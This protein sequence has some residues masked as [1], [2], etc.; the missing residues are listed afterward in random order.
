MGVLEIQ[1]TLYLPLRCRRIGLR[2]CSIAK[3]SNSSFGIGIKVGSEMK[4]VVALYSQGSTK[5]QAV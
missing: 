1:K 5:P 3:G 2:Y 4:E